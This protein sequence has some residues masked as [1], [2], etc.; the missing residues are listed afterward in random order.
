VGEVT[1]ERLELHRE[2]V[3]EQQHDTHVRTARA[4]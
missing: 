1:A 2:F 3:F 4:A